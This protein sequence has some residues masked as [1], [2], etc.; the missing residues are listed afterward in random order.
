MNAQGPGGM[1]PN[2]EAVPA[3]DLMRVAGMPTLHSNP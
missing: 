1:H 3:E 2:I